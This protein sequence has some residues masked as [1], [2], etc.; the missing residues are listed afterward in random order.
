MPRIESGFASS[1]SASATAAA[2]AG[3]PATV[4]AAAPATAVNAPFRSALETA[5]RQTATT[6]GQT[7]V[8]PKGAQAKKTSQ[9]VIEKISQETEE[10][11]DATAK[12]AVKVVSAKPAEIPEKPVVEQVSEDLAETAQKPAPKVINWKPA[13]T[14][15]EPDVEQ[16]EVKPANTPDEPTVALTSVKPAITQQRPVLAQVS[17]KMART[18]EKTT[19]SAVSQ[20]TANT[21][22]KPAE[23]PKDPAVVEEPTE[24]LASEAAVQTVDQ[25]VARTIQPTSRKQSPT[26]QQA[27]VAQTRPQTSKKT[28]VAEA[29]HPTVERIAPQI[30]ASYEKNGSGSKPQAEAKD[31]L[32]QP[33]PLQ[34]VAVVVQ[35]PVVKS[36]AAPQPAVSDSTPTT[37]PAPVKIARAV[38]AS[39]Q[40]V[41]ASSSD[42][43]AAPATDTGDSS[44]FET[45]IAT[46]QA[47]QAPAQP[48]ARALLQAVSATE[49]ALAPPPAREA[50]FATA[51]HQ[52]IV[53]GIRGQ[54]LPDGGTMHIRLA[55]PELGELHVSVEVSQGTI[56]AAFATSNDQATRL[57]THS[58]GQLKDALETTGITVG[59]LQ[60]AQVSAKSSGEGSQSA[61][62]RQ[63][64]DDNQTP[65]D[66][67]AQARD[68]Q[69]RE[70][71]RR[72]WQR[73][74][75]RDDLDLVA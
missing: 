70:L 28:A 71:L 4:N 68:Q 12:P 15:A 42:S 35:Q 13:E 75:G 27:A 45:E 25:P 19:P 3:A 18:T 37:Q 63:S 49:A 54:L 46:A 39:P 7:P 43:K 56:A 38:P 16:V 62:D 52:Q 5:Q 6:S 59:R 58:L 61:S 31:S 30:T 14:P 33:S 50:A 66:N 2:T 34:N 57:L 29:T 44:K 53:M 23:T 8:A 51:N 72:M 65:D 20:K 74:T 67:P 48:A 69:R 21:A 17:A 73:V 11:A 32:P 55:P 41:T 9:F 47:A 1:S 10:P 64:P 40:V 22:L 60:V 24:N 26:V 36:E